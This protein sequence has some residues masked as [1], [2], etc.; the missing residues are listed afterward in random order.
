MKFC[1]DER[2]VI[3]LNGKQGRVDARA[4]YKDMVNQYSVHFIDGHGDAVYGWFKETDLEL[5]DE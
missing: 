4:E 2:V 1:I 3:I 5:V